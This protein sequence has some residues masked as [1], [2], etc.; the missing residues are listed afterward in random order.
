VAGSSRLT[1][2]K[3]ISESP[4]SPEGLRQTAEAAEG[5]Q[6]GDAAFT[7]SKLGRWA[8]QDGTDSQTRSWYTGANAAGTDNGWDTAFY[9]K[10]M[11]DQDAALKEGRLGSFFEEAG[12]RGSSGVVTWD[13]EGKDGRRFTF[14]D[15]YEDGQLVGNVYESNDEDTA[16]LLMSRLVLE[17]SEQQHL[18]DP[19]ETAEAV[20]AKREE[21]K[22]QV[23]KALG[24]QAMQAK[25]DEREESIS[26]G[27]SEAGVVAGAAG[28]AALTGAGV[29]FAV[30]G[31]AG[32][33][34]GGVVGGG[35]GLVGGLLNRDELSETAARAYEITELAS[36]EHGTLGGIAEGVHQW[37]A[38]MGRNMSPLSNL[39]RGVYDWGKGDIGDRDSEFYKV[40]SK[41]D[42]EVPAWIRAI[43]VASS[44]GDGLLQ[45]ASPIGVS[46]FTAQM[47]SVI[48]GESA[49]L[50]LS[51]GEM[52][53]DE[54][55]AF[56]N[57]ATDDQ[58]NF[59]LGS[60]SAGIGKIGIDVA[61]LGMGRGLAS[62]ANA[63]NKAVGKDAVYREGGI[64]GKL[65]D[66]ARRK[67][68]DE[69]EEALAAGGS[70]V[71][72]GNRRFVQGA[73]GAI[74]GGAK[75][76]KMD[77]VQFLVPSEQVTALGT[78]AIARR[79]AA[80]DSGRAVT[81]DDYY[82]VAHDLALGNRT[83][84]NALVN[85]LG[86]AY[87]EGIQAVL[88][89]IATN[90][91][92]TP[93]EIMEG[94]LY[95]GAMGVGMTV[96]TRLRTATV[97]EKQFAKARVAYAAFN[98]GAELTKTQWKGYSEMEKRL[99]VTASG[100]NLQVQEA[101]L[102][103]AQEDQAFAVNGGVVA[104]NALK[105]AIETEF[106]SNQ[107]KLNNKVDQ[108]HVITQIE[109]A[110]SG[111]SDGVMASALQTSKNMTNRA[112]GI[113]DQLT[114]VARDAEQAAARA[115]ADPN[116]P[117]L[118]TQ[119]AEA[120]RRL[121][122]VT[123]MRDWSL[124]LDTIMD[125]ILGRVHAPGITD[126][127]QEAEI[128]IA[129]QF[130]RDVFHE[131]LDSLGQQ[132]LTPQDKRALSKALSQVTT[133]YPQDQAGSFQIF[134]PQIS[135]KL[136][137]ARADNVV[138]IS[139]AVLSALGADYDGDKVASQN[140]L[141]LDDVEYLNARAGSQFIG[142]GTSVNIAAPT[143]EKYQI[144]FMSEALKSPNVTLHAFATGVLM[145]VGQAIRDRYDTIIP[146]STLDDVITAFNT[147]VHNNNDKARAILIDGLAERASGELMELGRTT[148]QNEWLWLDQM[149][150][151]EMQQFQQS[152]AAH[153]PA[154]TPNTS[155][156]SP[157]RQTPETRE[158]H[159]E[160]A[161]V[162][163]A[164]LT[165]RLS[166]DS[167]FR[168]FQALHYSLVTA[169][170]E[171]AKAEPSN[172]ELRE[173]AQLYEE[174][175]QML[176]GTAV[177]EAITKDNITGMVYTQLEAIINNLRSAE[178]NLLS[179]EEQQLLQKLKTAEGMMVLANLE[180][181][182]VYIDRDG[183]HRS[184]D[185]LSLAQLL[186]KRA[187]DVDQAAKQGI[188]E[189]NSELQAK[190]ARLRQMTRPGGR[191]TSE[192]TA[193]EQTFVEI[194][195]STPLFNLLGQNSP[196]GG[197]AAIFGPHL[198]MEQFIRLYINQ[199]ESQRSALSSD[200]KRE[201]AYL[202]AG[203]KPK[204]M[205]WSL[206]D[207][208]KISAYRAVVDSILAV[209]NHRLADIEKQSQRVSGNFQDAMT[210]IRNAIL[211]FNE[212]S[213]PGEGLTEF[214]P[215]NIQRLFDSFP[216]FAERIFDLIPM[217]ARP[218]VILAKDDGY[219]VSRWFYD[220]F[221]MTP[222]EAEMHFWRNVMLSQWY[223]T[224]AQNETNEDDGGVEGEHARTYGKLPRRV[225]RIMYRLLAGDP[226]GARFQEFFEQLMAAKDLNAF[227]EWVN[228]Q[229]SIRGNQAPIAAWYDDTADFDPDKA[230]GGW[231]TNLQG[232]DM[233]EAIGMLAKAT[234]DLSSE[235]A[236]ERMAMTN[237]GQTRDAIAR[238]N[239]AV[240]TGDFSG[241]KKGDKKLYF[242]FKGAIEQAAKMR[243][244]LGPQAMIFQSATAA[245]G[246]YA[247]GHTKGKNPAH[248][249]P[250][251]SFEAQ[252]DGFD[253][254]TNYERYLQSLTTLNLDGVSNS[255]DMV[256]KDGGRTMDDHGRVIEWEKPTVASVLRLFENPDTRGLARSILFP[257]VMERTLDGRISPQ[258]LVGK[259]LK[260]F[261]D[262][263]TLGNLF[264]TDTELSQDKALI[265]VS[266][267]EA[268]ARNHG[269]NSAVQR[270]VNDLLIARLNG[271]TQPLTFE[272]IERWTVQAYHE[273]AKVLQD[274]ASILNLPGGE[275]ELDKIRAAAKATQRTRM[276]KTRFGVEATDDTVQ[277]VIDSIL[278]EQ[279]DTNAIERELISDEILLAEEAGDDARLEVLTDELN[280]I[281][282]EYNNLVERIALIRESDQV[283]LIVQMF[284]YDPNS[285]G[286]KKDAI[287]EYVLNHYEMMQSVPAAKEVLAKASIQSQDPTRAGQLDLED[288][289]WDILS[290]AVIGVYLETA[291]STTSPEVSIG[292]WP[293][294]K[295][296]Q[297][298]KYYDQTYGYL[299]DILDPAGPLA[300]AARQ[301]HRM[302]GRQ[303]V[304]PV[305]RVK[306]MGRLEQTIFREGSLGPWTGEIPR[307]SI[308]A[309]ARLDSAPAEPGIAI[310]GNLPKRQAVESAA[311][312]R[313]FE[314]PS[315]AMLSKTTVRFKQ[316][317][318]GNFDEVPVM[319]PGATAAV[320]RPL[321]Q[322]N[323]RF[324]RSVTVTFPGL[325]P[326][327]I[328][329]E[330]N[331]GRR[332]HGTGDISNSVATSGYLE[333]HVDRI[334]EAIRRLA[335]TNK[336]STKNL[337]A[338]QVEIEY[339]HP[340]S[341]PETVDGGP[342]WHNNIYFEGTNFKTD[343]DVYESLNAGLF[344]SF[345]G[346]N[347]GLQAEALGAS[348]KGLPAMQV[349]ETAPALTRQA[350]EADWATDLAGV[351]RAKTQAMIEQDLGLWNLEP[352]HYNAVYKAMKMRHWIRKTMSDGTVG[353]ISADDFISMQQSGAALPDSYELW[354]PSDQVLRSMLGEQGTQGVAR[355]LG[356][357]LEV[358][359]AKVPTFRGATDRMIELF[360]AGI[361]GETTSLEES[362][363]AARA[364]QNQL[365][366]RSMI[367]EKTRSAWDQRIIYLQGL[368]DEVYSERSRNAA[369][370]EGAFSPMTNMLEMASRASRMVRD[371]TLAIEWELGGVNI[372]LSRSE[373]DSIISRSLISNL[374]TAL[375]TEEPNRAGWFFVENG[376]SNPARGQLTGIS[377]ENPDEAV[378]MRVAPDDLVIIDIASFKG[379]LKQAKKRIDYFTGRGAVIVLT[380]SDG[381]TDLRGDLITYLSEEVNYERV[382]GSQH[383]Y[384]QVNLSSRY[385]NRRARA[386]TLT[387]MERISTKDRLAV[388]YGKGLPVQESAAWVDNDNPNLRSIGVQMNLVQADA[389]VDYNVPITA[390]QISAVRQH[391][392]GFNNPEDRQY[393]RD[394]AGA[395]IKD[396]PAGQLA[397]MAEFDAAFDRM[398]QRFTDNESSVL[399]ARGDTFQTGDIIPLIDSAGRV[400]LYRHG[401]KAPRN[402]EQINEMQQTSRPGSLTGSNVALYS[403]EPEP[404]ATTH[405]GKVVEFSARATSGLQVELAVDFQ[406]MGEKVQF[407]WNGT[408]FVFTPRPDSIVLPDH[409]LFQQWGIDLITGVDIPIEKEGLQDMVDNHRNAFAFFGID[410]IDDVTK[411]FFPTLASM[412]SAKQ[413]DARATTRELLNRVARQ[414]P[415]ISI[416]TAYNLQNAT[417]LNRMYSEVLLPIVS[418]SGLA[419]DTITRLSESSVEAQ[420]T[421]AMLIYLMTPDARVSDVMRSG[422][423]NDD[424]E[425]LNSTSLRM[426]SLFT[427]AFDLAP[428]GSALRTEMFR[429]F[430]EQ[431]YNP[432]ADGTGY[433]LNDDWEFQILNQDRTKSM[434]GWLAF[435]EVHASGDNPVKN[436]MT[437]SNA[438][439]E[440][441]N[442]SQ[443]AAN[444]A[445]LAFGTRTATAYELERSRRV[446]AQLDVMKFDG[447]EADGGYW[448]MMTGIRQ[449]DTSFKRWQLDSPAESARRKKARRAFLEFRKPIDKTPDAGW[450]NEDDLL[451]FEKVVRDITNHL[452]LQPNQ[453]SMV[454]GWIRQQLGMPWG[455]DGEGNISPKQAIQ[456]AEWIRKDV[457]DGYLP[458]IG[459]EVPL[460]DVSDLQMIFRANRGLTNSWVP[461]DALE[462]RAKATEWDSWVE[463]AL[464]SAFLTDNLFDPLYLLATDGFMHTYQNATD[465][466]LALPVSMNR[467]LT[468]ILM[469]PTTNRMLVSISPDAQILATDPTVMN[470][471]KGTVE[472]LIRGQRIT[473]SRERRYAPDDVRQQRLNARRK[474]RLENDT[475]VPIDITMRHFRKNG[476]E[477]INSSTNT[478][479]LARILINLRVGSAL[480]NPALWVS[481][482]P[483]QFVRSV[484]DTAA[485]VATGQASSGIAARAQAAAFEWLGGTR[486][487]DVLDKA[488]FT[489]VY[490][491]EQVE[492]LGRLYT[493]LGQRSDFKKMIYRELNFKRPGSQTPNR[494]ERATSA[495]ARAG[496]GMQDATYGVPARTLARRYMEAALESI[497]YEQGINAIS[498]DTLI[499]AMKTNPGFL[500]DNY[501]DAH[502]AGAAAVAQLR[503]LKPT[504]LSIVLRGIYE[505]LSE[506]PN[507]LANLFGNVVLKIPLLFTGYSMNVLTTLTGMQGFSDAFAMFMHG[508]EKSKL[509]MRLQGWLQGKP[510]EDTRYDFSEVLEGMDLSRSFIRGGLTHTGLFALGLAAGGLG[511]TGEDDE[512]R[513][514]RRAATLQGAVL[515]N[516]PRKAVEDMRDAEAMWI[517]STP[518]QMPWIARQ[519]IS[520]ILGMERFFDNGDPREIMWGFADALGSF[521]LINTLSWDDAVHTAAEF[522]AMAHSESLKDDPSSGPQSFGF[523]VAAAA[524]Y[525]RMLFENSFVNT[526]YQGWD[527]YD[528]DPFAKPML[529][530]EENIQR[531]AT[532]TTRP[533]DK[534]EPYVDPVTG[535]V[536]EGYINRDPGDA[537]VHAL[538]ENRA[539]LGMGLA[540]FTGKFLESDYLRRN[541]VPKSH[542]LE[543]GLVTEEQ[544]TQAVL[545]SLVEQG[546]LKGMTEAEANAVLSLVDEDG[547]EHL[548]ID[549]A[550]AV[551][552]GRMKGMLPGDSP[553]LKGVYITYEM[554]E[555]I[556]A[557]LMD[558]IVQE[559][560][561]S[562]LSQQ[563]ATTRM[564]RLWFGPLEDPNVV[565]IGDILWDKSISYSDSLEYYQLNTT[566]VIGPDGKPW[567]TGYQRPDIFDALGLTAAIPP[568]WDKLI[569]PKNS[570]LTTDSQGNTVDLVAQ[571]NTGMRALDIV[572]EIVPTEE[573]IGKSIVDAIE[574]LGK[575]TFEPNM[576]FNR[577]GGFG[578]YYSGGGRGGYSGGGGGYANF[579]EMRAL[580]GARTGYANDIPFINTSNP[581]IRRSN[582]RRERISSDRGRLNQWQ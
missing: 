36:E 89:P 270:Y 147:A 253:Y 374:T 255:L 463:I 570:T 384:K 302:A 263:I 135:K 199:S 163:G 245:W 10:A 454:E 231:S 341:L 206:N 178:T 42:R 146:A 7:G 233:R 273:V 391:L 158:R 28:G 229:P 261:L 281:D 8:A 143:Y 141:L 367:D 582:I 201:A 337:N 73:D 166:G 145:R 549:G 40:D 507:G 544:A 184:G 293:D 260:S 317:N 423:F 407:E 69:A 216:P 379:N 219:Y 564:K 185:R 502:K 448:R 330:P 573:E 90:D 19:Q 30:A 532:G 405:S 541:M 239:R 39:T 295:H 558:E 418:T 182:D 424:Q 565:G 346:A 466:L 383:V 305:S 413:Q 63:I 157:N 162:P 323:N 9:N 3:D 568:M 439:L 285:P 44:V 244:S 339:F 81:A 475:P 72:Q 33:L 230:G 501:P 321:A 51:G 312:R 131:R 61:Q 197:D 180:V 160:D 20:A 38:A 113:N 435:P 476:A 124:R 430:N 522:Q 527:R 401:M 14:G 517:G 60:L 516:D 348:K 31:P 382:N 410:F 252:R 70:I 415:R 371:E 498:T 57:I 483:E 203:E 194:F 462:G 155:T 277:A 266:L 458:T 259:D 318:Q 493:E 420:I 174:M 130:L 511:L 342:N 152:Y 289:E 191:G 364:R 545:T 275:D 212:F 575:K 298:Q 75:D 284:S 235:I 59:D 149:I 370:G 551:V 500:Q 375:N 345:A 125:E 538:T 311:G 437:F 453:G 450:E 247:Q 457:Y 282:R 256:A 137:K 546:G 472:D 428:L 338:A 176:T 262:G 92:W 395:S 29:G 537:Y 286:A 53:S 170:V 278:V 37:G 83:I 116:D 111:P 332:W 577:G 97:D 254:V 488:G 495:Y 496:L 316:L 249:R 150:R 62:G 139:H 96:G 221:N 469:D 444:T 21:N 224:G 27:A 71:K 512:E 456:M 47:A 354:V 54:R 485:N 536:K 460:M 56:K 168:M 4:A 552:R 328:I 172:T 23:P 399:P 204:G 164:T 387:T 325:Q 480:L 129:N 402:R 581:Y 377:L 227:I 521:P 465:S 357:E 198:T 548:T 385:Q 482:G 349:I 459:A 161:A 340:D 171:D 486:M 123:L 438:E 306:L 530:S 104:A 32:A 481:M 447:D 134:V 452:N 487:A 359:L 41:G 251:G 215:E 108:S 213:P 79:Q 207:S 105:D 187:L 95:G 6:S 189:G 100:M 17:D 429:R 64:T 368:R 78:R 294:A 85:G 329:L 52:Y 303:G 58:G 88:A 112:R 344:F 34:F 468:D 67:F 5:F 250:Q 515:M 555:A 553:A 268:E 46:A 308:D 406:T 200:L 49:S 222:A 479:S 169:K 505:P 237:E 494:I 144:D 409:G 540:I 461:R 563:Q 361:S 543:K 425:A 228:T 267:I 436:G 118:Q 241:V 446:A 525:E 22:F 208:E 65:P 274:A 445:Y 300:K 508:R 240:E 381:G 490:T 122:E 326:M 519:F 91:S 271:A 535:E 355:L 218:W 128:E 86:E 506:H 50:A 350:M 571:R 320:Q 365:V 347:A 138:Q 378:G 470:I 12:E 106:A 397:A 534:T 188:W 343:A 2:W 110:T 307:F 77:W 389:W 246:F 569:E 567:A 283:G 392:R 217:K 26:E 477:F 115:T 360:N 491:S 173:W 242:A 195:G 421:K 314:L 114:S 514:R 489:G 133:R 132:Q 518:V 76:A 13:H 440:K 351:I 68:S 136:T 550:E 503:S 248:V 167:L 74:V 179:R 547:R 11:K 509:V 297:N 478:T 142:A 404:N 324:A 336:V 264:P 24:A 193:A 390:T 177:S 272:E 304:E 400:L 474:W 464:G 156:V 372:T 120:Q 186:L 287:W 510:M 1:D 301:V 103:K 554:R 159:A 353:L 497:R 416:E 499:A 398:L 313:T 526:V 386:S 356:D 276:L 310:P 84:N 373:V 109:D 220:M 394:M 427:R 181:V 380:S 562:G 322:L 210:Q 467:G 66:W 140:Q 449:K 126:A 292:L 419:A 127:A 473:S 531:D 451:R 16:N 471:Q 388:F 309:N 238:Y 442:Y 432:R 520:P 366:V 523:L 223:S 533:T 94:A 151:V 55:G 82:R 524:T 98:G 296:E 25:I 529:D 99:L 431:L 580:P 107:A 15:I 265:Y 45:F 578:G 258:L 403:S 557:K 559:G 333:I 433:F 288:A 211:E 202:K 18:H 290:R 299:A 257:Q 121:T 209:G 243:Q 148:L 327:E 414:A 412:D 417:T 232:A 455:P 411:F 205:P 93:N 352:E 225:H 376:T 513:R 48:G 280:S 574:A 192:F 334:N 234:Q 331:V 335:R 153:R 426:P 315:E 291:A 236:E 319:L 190:H 87:E 542:T 363:I 269:G 175:G 119:L 35:I 422:G 434:F 393:L 492:K 43:D 408:K 576:G 504:P 528:R 226:T 556:Q 102:K 362:R 279:R 154:G 358:D 484:I 561:D 165:M 443:H 572:P 196:T 441:Q 80:K 214:S 539:T 183:N 560:V 101:G 369:R 579:Y 566:Y 396:N 117:E